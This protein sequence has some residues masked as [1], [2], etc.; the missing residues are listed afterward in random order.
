[1]PTHETWHRITITPQARAALNQFA[2]DSV[3]V[4]WGAR[5]GD[6]YVIEIDDETLDGLCRIMGRYNL[7]DYSTAICVIHKIIQH[8]LATGD[9]L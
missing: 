7:P 4:R 1:M 5:V 9:I 3:V 2:G 8:S 6:R